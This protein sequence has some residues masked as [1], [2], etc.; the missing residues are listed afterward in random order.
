MDQDR[1]FTYYDALVTMTANIQQKMQDDADSGKKIKLTGTEFEQTVYGA[2]L[3]VGIEPSNITHSP[4]KFP[5]FIISD[6]ETEE[7]IGIEVKKTDSAKWEVIGGSIYESLK[8]DIGETYVVMAKLGGDKPEVRI[9][10]YEEC[11]ADIKVTH[12]P[13]VYLNMDLEKGEDYLSVHDTKDL[14]ELSGDE[15]NRRIRQLL[16]TNKSTWWSEAETTAFSDL[17]SEEKDAY[18]VEGV[19]LF[20]EVFGGNYENF[21][22]WLIYNCLVWCKNVRDVFS[23]GGN[24]RVPEM[25]NIFVSAVMYRAIEKVSDIAKRI[26]SLTDEEVSK[27]WKVAANGV[28]DK[29]Y[30]WLHLVKSN[31]RLSEKL[32]GNNAKTE[33]YREFSDE[34]ITQDIIDQYFLLMRRKL[35]SL[36]D[37][38]Q[39]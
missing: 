19:V 38:E 31:L 23:A 39:V 13:R 30:V 12:S 28:L 35:L 11:I 16:R 26:D 10:R 6:P 24:K 1:V 20:P 36:C 29:K 5:D 3:D 25:Y 27:F 2:L 32:I 21:T 15:L 34:K 8:N 7:K 9:R 17:S 33:R 18:F 37:G 14:L 4:Q 22:P